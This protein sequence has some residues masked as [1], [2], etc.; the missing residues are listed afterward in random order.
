MVWPWQLPTDIPSAI[1]EHLLG[2]Q[3]EGAFGVQPGYFAVQTET[4]EPVTPELV[5]TR[6]D[7]LG[8]GGPGGTGVAHTLRSGFGKDGVGNPA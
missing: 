5:V 8:Q 7:I 3:G 4:M 1:S 6:T 2:W